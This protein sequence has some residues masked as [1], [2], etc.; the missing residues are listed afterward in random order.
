MDSLLIGLRAQDFHES[1]KNTT[2]FGPKDV[3]Y[4]NTLLIGKAAALAM[5]L[6]GLLYINNYTQL[7]Y[8]AASLGISSL[9]LPLVLDELEEVDFVSIV[10]LGS[11]IHRIDIRVPEFRSG[12]TDLGERLKLLKPSEV[13]LASI[14]LLSKLYDGPDDRD[15]L[16]KSFGLVLQRNVENGRETELSQFGFTMRQISRIVAFLI[17]LHH[18]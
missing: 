16:L 9:E 17:I 10:R 18:A 15:S 2:T 4:K 6:R 13:E 5:H 7:E 8:A 1:L 3:H 11:K 12:Y 14:H